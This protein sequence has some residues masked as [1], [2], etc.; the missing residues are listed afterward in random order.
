MKRL[1]SVLPTQRMRATLRDL[2][3]LTAALLLGACD[4]PTVVPATFAY[5]PT[6]L[7]AGVRYRWSTNQRVRVYVETPVSGTPW[8]L[9]DA[10]QRGVA[11]WNRVP[12]DDGFTLELTNA[13]A[14]AHVLVLDRASVLPV[15]PAD[16]C[17]FAPGGAGGYTYFCPDGA[18]ARALAFSDG[19]RGPLSVVIRVDMGR[20]TTQLEADAL[21]A[22]ELGHAIGIGGHS[23]DTGDVMYPQPRVATPS[24]R[25]TQ[26]LRWL[27]GQT[28]QLLL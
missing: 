25:D 6:G 12:S 23:A 24:G 1:M 9:R 5:D 19:T 15:V 28:A 13:R 18:R 26:T 10:V 2:A 11:Q 8:Q 14:G 17:A 22:H 21:V 16:A 3:K 20:A 27:L 7:T 4:S